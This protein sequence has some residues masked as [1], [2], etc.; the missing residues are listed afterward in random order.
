[1]RVYCIHQNVSFSAEIEYAFRL[2]FSLFGVEPQTLTYQDIASLADCQMD[3]LVSYGCDLPE[4]E[5]QSHI[6]IYESGFFGSDYLTKASLPRTP[7][8]TYKDV[9]I[10]FAGVTTSDEWV[11][12]D[13]L[14]EGQIRISSRIDLLASCFF[15]AT[16]Y[17]EIVLHERDEHDR[18]P[19]WASTAYQNG[20]LSRPLIHEYAALLKQWA[21]GVGAALPS[22][23]PWAGKRFAACITHD[24]DAVRR[25]RWCP[26]VRAMANVLIKDRDIKKAWRLAAGFLAAKLVGDPFDTFGFLARLERHY[27][28]DS[29][30]FFLAG[31]QTPHDAAYDLQQ[32]LVQRIFAS[33]KNRRNEI[34]LHS[35]YDT[36]GDAEELALEKTALES[37]AGKCV[38]GV[39]Q[40]FLR[41]TSPNDWMARAH[42]GFLYDSSLAFAGREGFRCGLAVP[43]RPF[44]ILTRE[45][46]DIWELPLHVMDGSLFQ[47][48]SLSAEEGAQRIRS[49]IDRVEA[50]GGVFV[51]L[52]HN[53]SLD[54]RSHP[55]WARTYE[56]VLTTLRRRDAL[57]TT[58][59][60][61][62]RL[63]AGQDARIMDVG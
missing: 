26:P 55:G 10:L 41:W 43:F 37:A 34:A 18:F 54:R 31:G 16:C 15:P 9:P 3:L 1:M 2:I 7:L 42:A 14:E 30:Y 60:E 27:E 23:F 13:R 57:M 63:W 59:A 56:D 12:C 53:S 38:E 52:W 11:A 28:F 5:A 45:E 58:A 24:V 36:S 25:Y 40:H 20:Y 29:T 21:A 49:I 51:L 19:A 39:R 44:N 33:L 35:S 61:V 62:T 6:H 32:R 22:Y 48:Q 4:M 50:T 47:Y 46:V 17:D 8:N